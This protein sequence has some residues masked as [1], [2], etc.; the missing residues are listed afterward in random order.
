MTSS[1]TKA[2]IKWHCRR[3]M[4][5]LDLML[6]RFVTAHLDTLTEPQVQVFEQLLEYPDPDIYSWLLGN[7]A[8]IEQEL[9]DLVSIIRHQNRT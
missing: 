1:A 7:D 4:L 3:G 8:P 5:E 9:I 6:D 2:K